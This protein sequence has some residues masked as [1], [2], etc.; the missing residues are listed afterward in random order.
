M[1]KHVK[2]RTVTSQP[3]TEA[4]GNSLPMRSREQII[5]DKFNATFLCKNV[6]PHPSQIPLFITQKQ[7]TQQKKAGK[8]KGLGPAGRTN[9]S[10]ARKDATST[11]A[12]ERKKTALEE[13][14]DDLMEKYNS[15]RNDYHVHVSCA[16]WRALE[17]L[18]PQ[19]RSSLCAMLNEINLS[20]TLLTQ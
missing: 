10:R 1:L 7:E 8:H 11:T 3:V 20:P 13:R 4:K 14:L 5:R 2:V 9:P 19:V 17:P 12:D 15:M 6:C 16:Q 18:I